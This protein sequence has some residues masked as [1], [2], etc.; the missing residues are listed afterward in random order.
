[1]AW[2]SSILT[3][4]IHQDR[5][6][7]RTTVHGVAESDTTERLSMHAYNSQSPALSCNMTHLFTFPHSV[8]ILQG[9]L[10]KGQE[11]QFLIRLSSPR[12]YWLGRR[13]GTAAVGR[14][15]AFPSEWG[16]VVRVFAGSFKHQMFTEY[17]TVSSAV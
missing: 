7:W 5:G 12:N 17:H 10:Q 2:H 15:Y 16:R 8:T 3:W 13:N 6:A 14:S 9:L 1:M 4:R 11:P